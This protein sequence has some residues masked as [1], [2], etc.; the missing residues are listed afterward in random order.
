[1]ARS[2]PKRGSG[3]SS[4]RG[5]GGKRGGGAKPNRLQMIGFVAT[6]LALT[7]LV[8]SL[9][10]GALDYWKSRNDP[11]PT[12]PGAERPAVPADR[13]RQVN[14][15]T[16]RVRVEVL[17][18]T[19]TAGLARTATNVLRDRGFDVVDT[20]NA[21]RGTPPRSVVIDRVGNLEQ[22][23]QVAAALGISHV[24]TRRDPTL[25]LEV[26]AIVGS[27]WQAPAN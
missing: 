4:P 10:W 15:P 17:N 19:R 6:W 5:G 8:G 9:L 22:A 25:I 16:R 26:T 3:A 24:E 20:K 1:M 11:P 12:A 13:G 7:A 18:A 21:P 14:A 23:R 2:K 27:D